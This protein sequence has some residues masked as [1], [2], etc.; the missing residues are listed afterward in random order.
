MYELIQQGGLAV[1]VI[2]VVLR[3]V[4]DFLKWKNGSI[5]LAKPN[6]HANTT[7]TG[8]LAASYWLREFA[9]THEGMR[10][11]QESLQRIEVLLAER[12]PK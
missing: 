5:A 6:P 10:Q 11:M 4:F 8:E 1:L 7:K 12:L 9:V 3:S 2:F